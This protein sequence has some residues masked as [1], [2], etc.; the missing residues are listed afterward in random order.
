MSAKNK[1]RLLSPL[2]L[3]AVLFIPYCYAKMYV[4]VDW[5]GCG[6]DEGFN[7]NDFGLVFWVVICVC[8]TV[9]SFFTSKVLPKDKRWLRILYILSV[10]VI[11]FL[12]AYFFSQLLI[13]K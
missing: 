6:C 10:F 3:F 7:A 1:L 8:A 5:F 9:M 11:S 2:L 13:V 12:I 4:F